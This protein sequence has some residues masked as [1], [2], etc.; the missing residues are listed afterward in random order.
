MNFLDRFSLTT[1]HMKLHK[2]PSSGSQVTSCIRTDRQTH[3]QNM[4]QVAADFTIKNKILRMVNYLENVQS[5]EWG[6]HVNFTGQTL[7]RTHGDEVW[8]YLCTTI[9]HSSASDADNSYVP[10]NSQK[11][12]LWPMAMLLSTRNFLHIKRNVYTK[13]SS[14]YYKLTKA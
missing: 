1:R 4:M 5:E 10:L 2:N 11:H 13:M 14:V 6:S 9:L 3:G 7:Y 8:Q 12:I